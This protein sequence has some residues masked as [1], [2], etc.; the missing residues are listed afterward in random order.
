VYHYYRDVPEGTPPDQARLDSRS[1]LHRVGDGPRQDVVVLARDLNPHLPVSQR[2]R[3]F[4]AMSPRSGWMLALVSHSALGLGTTEFLTDC[5][6]Y[7]APRG[8]LADPGSCRWER[9][10]E[11][12]D[13]V[14]AYA[15][16]EDMLYLVTGRDA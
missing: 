9:V 11:V 2:D 5:T 8:G 15:L 7:V 4:M 10:A 6:L 12:E 3:P 14:V 1:L 16:T 13:D